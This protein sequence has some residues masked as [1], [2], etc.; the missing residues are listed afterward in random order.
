MKLHRYSPP[1]PTANQ[2]QRSRPRGPRRNSD[3]STPPQTRP[4]TDA[5]PPRLFIAGLA[6][7]QHLQAI[8]TSL[9][10]RSS[11]WT[12][13][14]PVSG[15]IMPLSRKKSCVRCR[16]SKVGC[17]LALPTCSRCSARLLRCVYDG[18]VPDRHAPYP[19]YPAA[20]SIGDAVS[21]LEPAGRLVK[22]SA[23]GTSSDEGLADTFLALQPDDL[24]LE[25]DMPYQLGGFPLL[26]PKS[27]SSADGLEPQPSSA[28]NGAVDPGHGSF[29][30]LPLED[31]STS[32]SIPFLQHPDPF[33]SPPGSGQDTALEQSS[34][35]RHLT[36]RL[37]LRNCIMTSVAMGQLTSY[38]KMLVEGDRLPPFIHPECFVDDELAPACAAAG[39]H[40]CL[41]EFLVNCASLVQL[42]YARVSADSDFVWKTIYTEFA[43]L[44]KEFRDCDS[45]GRLATLQCITVYVLL[46]AGDPQSIE[47]NNVQ[48]LLTAPL[49]MMSEMSLQADWLKDYTKRPRRREWVVFE[50][51]RRLVSIYCIIDLLLDGFHCYTGSN[52]GGEVFL[53]APLPCHRDMWE[54]RNTKSWIAAYDRAQ[55][56]RVTDTVL[57][58]GHLLQT[59]RE[60][61][62]I[63]LLNGYASMAHGLQDVMNWCEGMDTMGA[64]IWMVM[65]LQHARRQDG[66][67][68]AW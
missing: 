4:L 29:S 39:H 37:I 46:Q 56:A 34:N 23:L 26:D 2:D 3:V 13:P 11:V 59:I 19:F 35:R 24:V 47:K 57:T 63:N 61:C 66:M 41:H 30:P 33:A 64:L 51:L 15:P 52:Q 8:D 67:R 65:P 50:S 40:V 32:R 36:R 68:E 43:K 62:S 38:P 48:Q 55:S 28:L 25:F 18:Q 1:M 45:A 31:S 17:N 9:R 22:S 14:G 53:D 54:S 60:P 44:R 5:S 16:E 21:A 27:S 7:K 10:R 42:F 20:T 6:A 49:D 58:T 12:L